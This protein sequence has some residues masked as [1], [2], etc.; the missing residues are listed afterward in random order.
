M[1]NGSLILVLLAV[2]F[3]VAVSN[4][5]IYTEKKEI[6]IVKSSQQSQQKVAGEDKT[7]ILFIYSGRWKFLRIQ[8]AHVYREL[9]RNGG[10]LDQVWFMM[11]MYDNETLNKLDEF[12]RR[13]N[14][15]SKREIFRIEFL[16]LTPGTPPST[17]EDLY[18]QPYFK[19]F[20][21]LITYP[22]TSFFKFDDDIVYIHPGAFR[23]I[24][25][26]KNSSCFMHFFNIAGSNWR[27]SW[28]HQ[29]N[30]VYKDTNP[31]NLKFDYSPIAP[32][33]WKGLEC[34]ELTLRTFLHHYEH[35]TLEK[36]LFK[37]LELTTDRARFS[38]NAFLLDKDLIDIKALLEAGM[39]SRDDEKWWTMKYSSKVA[40]PN[41][42][43]GEAMVVH[44]AYSDVAK[45]MLNLN[46]LEKFED[47]VQSNF[48]S[49]FI[50]PE[51]WKILGYVASDT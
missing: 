12:T 30:G 2:G 32:C 43:V 38:I 44:F 5:Y 40:N 49:F 22:N 37:S 48:S 33:G 41:C 16:G 23:T 17:K 18:A 8:L 15:L 50:E 27:C 31:K 47:I 9:R 21:H 14:S 6:T 29:R 1:K 10:I 11:I 34:A 19:V 42:V 45:K 35:K 4:F 7:N 25:R 3:I 13:A 36:Y 46:F 20:S 39:I 24:A 26:Q 28:I 51:V